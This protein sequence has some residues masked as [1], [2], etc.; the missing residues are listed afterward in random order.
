MRMSIRHLTRYRYQPDAASVALRLRLWPPATAGQRPAA[1]A[2][3]VNGEGVE[4][5]MADAQGDRLALWHAHAAIGL[6]EILAE[7]VVETA[8]LAGVLKELPQRGRPSVYLRTTPLTE[9]SDA[10]RALGA[11]VAETDVLA[12][13]HALS[14][15]VH[16]AVDYRP[17][18]SYAT[19]TAAEALALGAGVCQDQTHVFI[20]AA[21]MLEIPARYVVGYLHDPDRANDDGHA[22]DTHAWAEAF[23]PGLGWTGFDI[24][25]QLCPTDLYVRLC[26]GLDAA[27]AAPVRGTV[28]GGAEEEMEIEIAVQ[29]G[30][31]QS[32]QQQQQS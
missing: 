5:M 26:C 1:W 7:G 11:G 25:N 17:G 20:A 22:E 32:Q 10:I 6:V 4:P 19:T 18:V 9:T 2:V 12:R 24:T 15:A 21:R 28:R 29:A 23:V 3:S 8:D 27:D 30:A 14:E 31:S 13:C 16:A